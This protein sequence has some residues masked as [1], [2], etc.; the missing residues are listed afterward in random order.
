MS[1]IRIR[2]TIES[3]TLTLPELKAFIGR[4]VDIVI[5]EPAVTEDTKKEFWTAFSNLPATEA[6]FNERQRT[7]GKWLIDPRFLAY[8][9][10]LAHAATRDYESMRRMV[11]ALDA[12]SHLVDYDYQAQIDQ[13][14]CDIK[15]QEERLK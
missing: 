1:A 14:A 7:F 11:D 10:T 12:T 9:P 15:D 8:W 4:T 2:K 5:E 13:D 3:D 6:E